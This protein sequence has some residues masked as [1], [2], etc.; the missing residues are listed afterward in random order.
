MDSVRGGV[1]APYGPSGPIYGQG[2]VVS[3]SYPPPPPARQ[4]SRPPSSQSTHFPL[5][6]G[7]A[8]QSPKGSPDGH[9]AE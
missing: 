8:H 6:A 3:H 1:P 5:G 4:L 9:C 7:P 2:S